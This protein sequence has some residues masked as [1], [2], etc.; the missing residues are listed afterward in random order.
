MDAGG[1][2]LLPLPLNPTLFEVRASTLCGDG[3]FERATSAFLTDLRGLGVD[4]LYILGAFSVLSESG[5]N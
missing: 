4:I 2:N 3:T 1:A 5:P